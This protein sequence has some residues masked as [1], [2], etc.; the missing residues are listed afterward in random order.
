MPLTKRRQ[1]LLGMM[2]AGVAN[3][4]RNEFMAK[5]K[6]SQLQS[7]AEAQIAEDPETFLNTFLN[8]DAQTSFKGQALIKSLRLTQPTIP[9]D[10]KLSQL[11]IQC[12]RIAT[13]QYL[14][15][16]LLPDYDGSI[17]KLPAYSDALAEYRQVASFRGREAQVTNSLEVQ[18]PVQH[19]TSDPVEQ[20]LNDA[21]R[22][23]GQ[24]IKQV[25]KIRR[26]I[27]VYLGF[28]LTS[29]KRN[30]IVFRGT[31]TGREWLNNLTA[32]QRPYTDPISGQ[33]FGRVH[34][35]FIRNYL[36]IIQ[37]LPRQVAETLNSSIP[38]YVT[39]HS[40]GA[41][42]ATIAALDIALNVPRLRPQLQLYTYASPR[43]G[44]KTFATLHSRMIPNSYRVVNLADTFTLLPPTKTV[45][46]YLH[47]GQEWSFISAQHDIV[48]NHVVNTYR[49]A[50]N[51]QQE[52]LSKV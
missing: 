22:T 37:P 40:L 23:I 16:N 18:L 3:T 1:F 47:I 6:Q 19:Q 51:N 7:L 17:K 9:Y 50:I 27:P 4:L 48:P 34:E 44:D 8:T 36:K 28:V 52:Q 41:S 15:G 20:N 30:I 13:E 46:T 26:E 42:Q 21:E 29:A 35:G 33:Y 49:N 32:L 11:L 43:V 38:C 25:V 24:T 39:G 14:T 12:S 45:G 10:R 31:Q 2:T 5:Q